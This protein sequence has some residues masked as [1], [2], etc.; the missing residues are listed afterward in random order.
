[1]KSFK[2]IFVLIV[3]LFFTNCDYLSQKPELPIARL[4]EKYLLFSEIESKIPKNLDKKDSLVF[5]YD[6]INQ[7]AKNQILVDKSMIN[8]NEEEQQKLTNLVES[9]KSDLFSHY[10]K[11]KIVKTSI[12]TIIDN[13]EIEN[14]YDL[15]KLNFKLNE[16]LLLGR[17]IKISKNN[18]NIKDIR[19]RFRRFNYNDSVFLDSIS[20]QFSSFSFNDTTWTNN[21]IFFSKFPEIKPY[22]KNNIVK[23]SLFYQIEDSLELYLIKVNRSVFRNEIAPIDYLQ[24]TLKQILLN[25]RKLDFVNKFEKELIEDAVQSKELEIYENNL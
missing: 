24:P 9:Y 8:L 3:V 14:Y 21:D 12:D 25:K 18:Y 4:K 15:N 16:D 6:Q 11:E 13:E 19:R 1:L 20:L 5:I 23:K 2:S 10:Y 17:Y 22:I 7:W